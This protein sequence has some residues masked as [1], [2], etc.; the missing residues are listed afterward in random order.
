MILSRIK[1]LIPAPEDGQPGE[2][3]QNAVMYYITSSVMSIDADENGVPYTPDQRIL[4]RQWKREGAT[5]A[6]VSSD[7][8]L[9]IYS[10]K[11]GEKTYFG[12]QNWGESANVPV[13][14]AEGCDSL[15]AELIKDS[16]G[17]IVYSLS[18]PVQKK[19]KPGEDGKNGVTYEI[20]P[21]VAAISADADGNIIT[22]VISVEAYKT[23]GETRVSCNV[24][25]RL[26]SFDEEAVPYY[27]VQYKIDSGAWTECSKISIP[28]GILMRLGYGIPASNVAKVK[29]GITL[30]L[31]YGTGVSSDTV[32]K[33]TAAIPVVKD[34]KIGAQGKPGK[35]Y[36]YD[37]YFD[38]QKEYIASDYQ[39]PYVA[40]DWTDKVT[41]NGV[42]TD[43]VK[44]SYYMLVAETN[45]SGSTFIAPRTTAAPGVWEL[46][47]TS[48]KYLITEAFFSSFA[49]LG[50]AVFS[51]DWMISQY[52]TEYNSAGAV[53]NNNSCNYQLFG[54]D[55]EDPFKFFYPHI[56]LDMLTGTSYLGKTHIAGESVMTGLVKRRKTI[57]TSSN[58]SQYTRVAGIY[59]GN[60]FL[61]LLLEKAGTWMEFT[62]I[63]KDIVLMMPAI[64]SIYD[65]DEYYGHDYARALEGCSILLY[66]RSEHEISVG[67]LY[68][69]SG[70]VQGVYQVK[71]GYFLKMKAEIEVDTWSNSGATEYSESLIWKTWYGK[72]TDEGNEF[73]VK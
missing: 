65:F 69:P 27:Y 10:V 18:I 5:S 34:G 32:K 41:V 60:E 58:I 59:E 52:G 17:D 8:I 25:D 9:R 12:P 30:R 7:N 33:L 31:L 48:F 63:S 55:N 11:A 13:A 50:S 26:V 2:P 47:E 70:K 22:G 40:F 28:S 37:G 39:A 71:K 68:N 73:N 46:M 61:E 72:I 20:V 38:T 53:I 42:A 43:V 29:T 36:Y 49:K 57:I 67:Y 21:S 4:I 35:F 45:K 66:N 62:N 23:E 14:S 44:T 54:K 19:G 56:A 3:G 16:R 64:N 51:G 1:N 15:L 24:G 6:V